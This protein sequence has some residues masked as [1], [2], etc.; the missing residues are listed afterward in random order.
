MAIIV[1]AENV[2]ISLVFAP[3]RLRAEIGTYYTNA[4]PSVSPQASAQPRFRP[5]NF[6]SGIAEDFIRSGESEGLSDLDQQ[7]IST[8]RARVYLSGREEQFRDQIQWNEYVKRTIQTGTPYLDHQ[9]S[10]TDPMTTATPINSS[11]VKNYHDPIYEDISKT[12]ATNQLLNW[13]LIS[14]AHK[15]DVKSVQKVGDIKTTFDSEDYIV[16]S[17]DKFQELKREF[18]NRLLNYSGSITE[19]DEKQRNIFDLQYLAPADVMYSTYGPQVPIESFPFYYTKYLPPFVGESGPE[20]R[21]F[22]YI[23]QRWKKRKNIFQSIKQDLSFS[24]RNFNIDGSIVE[25]K[26]H[27]L[28][29]LLTTTRIIGTVERRDELFLVPK[30]EVDYDDLTG[31]F[32]DQVNTVNF[33]AEM[34]DFINTNSRT[35]EEILGQPTVSCKTFFLGYKIEKYIDNDVGGPIQTYY[36]N[37]RNFYDTQLKYGRKYIYKTKMLVGVLG[38]SY[39]YSNLFISQGPVVMTAE[40]GQAISTLPPGYVDIANK[41]YRAYVD[42]E[43]TPSFQVLEYL[44]DTDEATF[45]DTP[46]L[47][48]QVDFGNNSKKANVEFFLSPMFG[49]VL[50]VRPNPTT[51]EE[52]V[53]PLIPLTDRDKDLVELIDKSEPFNPD[54]FK[55]T[56]EIYRMSS[57]PE[58]ESDFADH[59]LATVDDG[60]STISSKEDSSV[61]DNLNAHFE[62][63]L[64]PNEKYYYAF[65]T[66]SYHGTPS[67]LTTPYELELLRDSDE[68]KVVV[69]QYKYPETNN[70][71]YRKTAKRIIKVSPNIERLIFDDIDETVKTSYKLDGA[72]MLTKGQT[73]TFKIRVTSKHTGKKIDINLNLKLDE[74]ANSFTQN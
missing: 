39:T 59:L 10:F 29:N 7:L 71:V 24:N 54:Y 37:D 27:N 18:P 48:P 47:P 45:I 8:K 70:H 65:R 63:F 43:A 30:A 2:V 53:R 34:T 49:R 1:D 17:E 61:S 74:D 40:N 64:I 60:P 26:I 3:D 15:S 31:R 42:V 32:A 67:N 50:S 69:S 41:K 14:Y 46:S 25:G 55:G 38:S 16:D 51:P 56:Y 57:P 22:N 68:Y 36:T 62:D 23:L 66:L 21:R 5:A 11:F 19:V 35:P 58:K 13:N 9:F 6:R 12:A 33:L 52:L 44:L 4:P 72:N 20:F 28:I 73:T